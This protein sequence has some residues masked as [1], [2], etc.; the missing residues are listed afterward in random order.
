MINET[1]QNRKH[2]ADAV[3]VKLGSKNQ[4]SED[5]LLQSTNQIFID[6]VINLQATEVATREDSH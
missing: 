1:F 5:L 4:N 2:S 6:E 3:K